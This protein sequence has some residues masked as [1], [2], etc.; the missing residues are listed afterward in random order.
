MK[1]TNFLVMLVFLLISCNTK[2][3]KIVIENTLDFDRKGEIVEVKTTE[4]TRN[5]MTLTYIL[6]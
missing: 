1:H 4:I 2:S 3:T 5:L 6:K